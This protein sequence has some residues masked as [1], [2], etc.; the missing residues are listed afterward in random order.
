MSQISK[1]AWKI[2]KHGGKLLELHEKGE[3]TEREVLQFIHLTK[4]RTRMIHEED[5]RNGSE[6]KEGSR[7][8][9]PGLYLRPGQQGELEA[10]GNSLHRVHLPTV[11]H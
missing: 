1:L 7:G 5:K 6:Q 4:F 8:Q 3:L 11:S 9:V 10:A 2:A